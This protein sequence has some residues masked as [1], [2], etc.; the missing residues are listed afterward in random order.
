[1]DAR[2][3]A[4]LGVAAA[5]TVAPGADMALVARHAVGSG[6][7]AAL[8]ASLGIAC[9]CLLHAVASSLGLSAVLARSAAAYDAVRLA[10]A[11]Y[12]LCLGIQALRG[13]TRA[14]AGRPGH[15][16]DARSGDAR[17]LRDGLVTNLLNPKVALFYLTYLPQ[18]V[19]AGRPVLPQSL[20]L[21][22]IHV[23]MGLAWLAIY[24]V[25]VE[26]L[27]AVLVGGRGRRVIEAITGTLLVGLAL[28][29]AL[30]RRR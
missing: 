15:L 25:F 21:S 3:A 26:R 2:L 24:A 6:R 30:E 4:F 20:L 18:F 7:R 8:L 16:H 9:G 11:A 10:G 29:L 19:D 22:G 5:L 13:G 12:L 23:A 1:M 14:E 28:R 27:T 17:Y